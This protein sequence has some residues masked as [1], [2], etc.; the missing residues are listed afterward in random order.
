APQIDHQADEHADSSGAE[1]PVIA[2][3]LAQ[4]SADQRGG[5]DGQADRDEINLE[6]VGRP[7]IS[8]RVEL[9]HL[10]RYVS[11]EAACAQEYADERRQKARFEC[12]EEMTCRHQ[13]SPDHHGPGSAQHAIGEKA[14]AYRG[15][16]NQPGIEAENNRSQR[17]RREGTVDDFDGVA[18]HR[19][20]GHVLD[21]PGLQQLMRHVQHQKRLHS[22]IGEAL[23]E[24]RGAQPSETER[25][26]QKCLIRIGRRE[27]THRAPV[28]FQVLRSTFR[29]PVEFKRN[30]MV[31]YMAYMLL[32][33][34]HS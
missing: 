20:A 13:Q 2:V 34:E 1:T 33:M 12:H 5:D 23:P 26:P 16:E 25:M 7:W 6:T 18:K 30:T 3:S 15:D 4:G 19:E 32:Y 27:I 10:R 11:L 31:P 14:S 8:A 24:F 28:A 21:V 17:L 29:S 22:V 9:T